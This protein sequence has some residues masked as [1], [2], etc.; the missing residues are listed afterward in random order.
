MR[1]REVPLLPNV[2]ELLSR[3]NANSLCQP[4]ELLLLTMTILNLGVTPQVKFAE[5]V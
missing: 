5:W 3:R 1:L 4:S 2:T